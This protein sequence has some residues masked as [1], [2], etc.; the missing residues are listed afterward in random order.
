MKIVPTITCNPCNPVEAKN[1]VPYTE[2]AKVN[3]AS[4]YSKYCRPVKS[5]ANTIVKAAPLMA[6]DLFPLIKAWCEYVIKAPEDNSNKVF[7]RGI[8]KGFNASIPK[9]GHEDPKAT[10]GDKLAWK[11]PQNTL[12]KAITSDMINNANPIFNPL[13]TCFV[14]LPRY[15]PSKIISLNHKIIAKVVNKNPKLNK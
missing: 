4:T 2:S 10:S 15:V 3:P 1:T 14:W 5:I 13:C 7:R 6:P 9:G 11:N 8:P 12:I